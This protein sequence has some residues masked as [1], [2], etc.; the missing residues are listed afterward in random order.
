[1]TSELL[2]ETVEET[3]DLELYKS[4]TESVDSEERVTFPDHATQVC[5]LPELLKLN[6]QYRSNDVAIEATSMHH[7]QLDI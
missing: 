4:A 2:D 7:Y 3:A 5:W 6:F 1:M